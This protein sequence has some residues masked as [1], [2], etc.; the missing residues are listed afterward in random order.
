M[1]KNG[2]FLLMPLSNGKFKIMRSI[3]I[4]IENKIIKI[5]TGFNTDLASVPKIFW[6]ILP[7]FGKYTNAAIIHD[8]LYSKYN[9]TDINRK[10]ADRMFLKIMKFYK[11][12]NIKRH[13]I[14]L[15]VRLF[16]KNRWKSKVKIK[17]GI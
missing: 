7:P 16:G 5:P 17:G 3:T 10:E 12:N 4:I 9:L 15:A 8:F 13:L 6:P 14:Y 2:F 1:K 11:V